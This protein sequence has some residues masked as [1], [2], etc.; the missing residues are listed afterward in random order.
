MNR[1]YM[2]GV[3]YMNVDQPTECKLCFNKICQKLKVETHML[4]V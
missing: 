4:N 1:P 2:I 3:L